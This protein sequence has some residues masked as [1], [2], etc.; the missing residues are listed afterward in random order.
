[1]DGV[2]FGVTSGAAGN[3]IIVF[4]PFTGAMGVA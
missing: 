3:P 1:L 4:A 2:F